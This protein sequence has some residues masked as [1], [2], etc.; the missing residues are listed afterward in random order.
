MA[1]FIFLLFYIFKGKRERVYMNISAISSAR[2]NNVNFG[3][4]LRSIRAKSDTSEKPVYQVKNGYEKLENILE[5]LANVNQ[6]IVSLQ[7]K[8]VEVKK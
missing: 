6:Q 1:N 3:R 8:L 4:D 5:Q 7:E 2:N